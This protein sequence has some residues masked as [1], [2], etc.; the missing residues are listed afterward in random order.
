M[1]ETSRSQCAAVLDV[2]SNT[3]KILLGELLPNGIHI[4]FE[5]TVEC[6]ISAGMYGLNRCL[7][8]DAITGAV[9][10]IEHLLESAAPYLP[11]SIEI[12]AT[13]AVRDADNRQDFLDLV[14]QRTGRSVTVLSGEE[15]ALGIAN[16][17]A[18]EPALSVDTPLTVTDLGGGSL[19]WILK[20]GGLVNEVFSFEL[21]AV[22]LMSLF[23]KDSSAPLDNET[24]ASIRSHCGAL[25]E[26]KITK[27]KIPLEATH[28]GTG[29]AF[30]ISRLLLATENCVTMANQSSELALP[31]LRRIEEIL[32]KLS[33]SDR[34]KYPGLPRT[35]ADILPVALNVILALGEVLE[36]SSFHHSFYNLRMGRLANLLSK[37][38]LKTKTY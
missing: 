6:R 11:D 8:S 30:T 33:L 28:W 24:K 13:S 19:E 7:S 21:G 9:E 27:D 5:Q 15:E 36:A 22:K 14:F 16:G 34:E 2:G 38:A 32:S 29:G 18:Q 25:F 20:T 37:S 26:E 31:D 1:S 12:L 3:I 23:V 17:I 10:A 4:L 35:R